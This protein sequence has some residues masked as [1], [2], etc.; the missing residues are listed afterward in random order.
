MHQENGFCHNS[1]KGGTSLHNLC[2]IHNIG[3][4]GKPMQPVAYKVSPTYVG[5]VAGV[6]FLMWVKAME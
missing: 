1:Y 5:C 2:S 4:V 6:V 3:I